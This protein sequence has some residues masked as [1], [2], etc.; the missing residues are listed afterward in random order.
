M[1]G[2]LLRQEVRRPLEGGLAQPGQ[3][4]AQTQ[5]RQ[6]AVLLFQRLEGLHNISLSSTEPEAP[7]H[8]G[9]VAMQ[10]FQINQGMIHACL[11]QVLGNMLAWQNLAHSVCTPNK[12]NCK[13]ADANQGGQAKKRTR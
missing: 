4:E 2:V 6:E 5:L 12:S 8:L 1:Q 7:Q 3:G 11:C 10:G 9:S 13:I